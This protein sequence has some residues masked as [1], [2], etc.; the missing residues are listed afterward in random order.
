LRKLAQPEAAR[1]RAVHVLQELGITAAPIAPEQVAAAKKVTLETRSDFPPDVYGALARR[2]NQFW[3]LVSR[4]CPTGGHRR[5]TISHELGHYH[6]DGH[7]EAL[8]NNAD[9]AFSRG[10]NYRGKD[11]YEVEADAFASELL[12]PEALARPVVERLVPGIEAVRAI[13]DQFGVSLSAAAIRLA[14]LSP[15]PCAAIL[16]HNRTVEWVSFSAA[17]DGY[18]WTRRQRRGDWAPRRSGTYAL[19]REHD[20]VVAGDGESGSVLLCEWFEGAP[21]VEATDECVGLG[22]YGRVLTIL[23]CPDLPAAEG[24][25]ED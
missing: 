8:L 12:M 10:G 20:R 7:L 4:A 17:F 24:E 21:A 6:L 25:P 19:A 11:P 22:P 16:C 3:I 15:E 9:V 14:M 5:F 18:S 23:S 1:R 2:G 13:A